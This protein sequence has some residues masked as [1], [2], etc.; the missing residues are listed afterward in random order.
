VTSAPTDLPPPPLPDDTVG[1]P[2]R[3]RARA[4]LS[5]ALVLLFTGTLLSL[6]RFGRGRRVYAPGRTVLEVARPEDAAEAWKAHGLAGRTL[7]L[8]GPFPH[9]LRASTAEAE[10]PREEQD[11]VERAALDNVVRR[12]YYVVPD[13][14]WDSLFGRDLPGFFRDAPGLWR[15]RYLHYSLGLPIIATT[16]TSLPRL[17]EPVL[18]YVDRTR[19]DPAFAFEVLSKLGMTSD[20]I[21]LTGRP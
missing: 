11:F 4:W 2:V 21:V 1:D 6:D 18:L 17:D 8:F 10:R 12:V 5:L 9:L 7:L 16:P 13:D 20:F 19:F 14:R 15:G 3:T